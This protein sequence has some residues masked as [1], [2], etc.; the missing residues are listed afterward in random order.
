LF[1]NIF[2]AMATMAASM[3][4][5][6]HWDGKGK[7]PAM[8]N[9]NDAVLSTQTVRGQLALL[10]ISWGATGLLELWNIIFGVVG[11]K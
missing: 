5:G 9:Y 8:T 6:D 11:G 10:S 3:Y 2:V 7:V 1:V 4:I